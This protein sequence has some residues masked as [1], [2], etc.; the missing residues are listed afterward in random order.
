MFLK[1]DGTLWTCGWA[2]NGRLGLSDDELAAA[3][4]DLLYGKYLTVP[5]QVGLVDVA[6]IGGGQ[7]H[8]VAVQGVGTVWAWGYNTYEQL[9]GGTPTSLPD[10]VAIPVQID[11]GG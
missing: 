7:T 4:D 10:T 2:D 3:G 6:A 5:K 8:S 9:C 1:S 11:F